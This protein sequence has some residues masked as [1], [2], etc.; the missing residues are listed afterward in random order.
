MQ[1]LRRTDLRRLATVC[2]LG[3]LVLNFGCGSS[4]SKKDAE[5]IIREH[6]RFP[7]TV[8][9]EF[10]VGRV[11]GADISL[12]WFDKADFSDPDH[13][14]DA[15]PDWEDYER[16]WRALADQALIEVEVLREARG[17]VPGVVVLGVTDGGRS[18]LTEV[19]NNRWKIKICTREFKGITNMEE[20]DD[21]TIQVTFEW[22][23]SNFSQLAGE[24]LPVSDIRRRDVTAPVVREIVL[25]KVSDSQWK[26]VT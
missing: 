23:Y 21:R 8:Y 18:A 19:K 26:V 10:Q 22:E 9:F 7:Q 25:R 20:I 15:Y 5:Q 6:Y 3:A 17:I 13:W 4:P 2:S 16:A 11:T 1:L 12:E 24:L 14:D